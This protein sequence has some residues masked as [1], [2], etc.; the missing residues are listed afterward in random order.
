MKKILR[1]LGGSLFTCLL[2]LVA[3]APTVGAHTV[4][5][6]SAASLLPKSPLSASTLMA[7]A[8]HSGKVSIPHGTTDSRLLRTLS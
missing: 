6:S 7:Q 8:I 1:L 2:I 3:L 4:Q 5:Q